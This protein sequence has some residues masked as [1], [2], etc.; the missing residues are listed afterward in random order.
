[1]FVPKYGDESTN[2]LNASKVKS[3]T[4]K[5]LNGLFDQ[6]FSIELQHIS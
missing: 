3:T 4:S 6:A 5:P 2:N 1:M